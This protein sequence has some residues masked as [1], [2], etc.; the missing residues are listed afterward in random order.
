MSEM[1]SI[2]DEYLDETYDHVDGMLFLYLVVATLITPFIPYIPPR[3][4]AIHLIVQFSFIAVGGFFFYRWTKAIW[5]MIKDQ[6]EKEKA[7]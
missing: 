1:R 4:T 7:K 2:V 6:E 3:L 5:K